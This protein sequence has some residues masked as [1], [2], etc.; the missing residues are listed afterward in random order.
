MVISNDFRIGLI[1]NELLFYFFSS[2]LSADIPDLETLPFYPFD[3]Y[4]IYNFC[5]AP[6]INVET[7]LIFFSK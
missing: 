2:L 4:Y 3:N 1:T 5:S 6:S 7:L